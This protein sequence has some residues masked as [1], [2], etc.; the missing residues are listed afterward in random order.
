M[1]SSQALSERLSARE[2]P[3]P[4][5]GDESGQFTAAALRREVGRCADLLTEAGASAGDIIAVQLQ[6]CATLM[7]LLLAIWRLDARAMLLDHRLTSAETARLTQLCPPGF[8]VRSPSPAAHFTSA[9]ALAIQPAAAEP[10]SAEPPPGRFCLVQFTSGST[11]QSKVVA[12][13]AASLDE[14]LDRYAAIENMPGAEDRLLLLSSPVHTWGLVGGIL[15]GL[16]AGM[17]VLFASAP[18]GGAAARAAQRLSATAIFGVPSHFEMLGSMARPPPL[19]LLR[20]ATSAGAMT[21]EKVAGRFRQAFGCPLGQVYG[22]T[23]AGVVASDIAG[24]HDP[25][26]VGRPAPGMTVRVSGG[27]LYIRL[28]SSPYLRSDGVSRFDAG[29]LRTF[30]RAESRAADGVLSILGRADSVVSIGGNKID[31]MEIEQVLH[32]HPKVT[33]AVVTFGE[34]I[35][36]HIAAR[37]GLTDADLAGWCRRRLSP[38]KIPKRFLLRERLSETPTGKVIR[39]REQLLAEHRRQY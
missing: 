36:A 24:Q 22:L 30:D 32:E 31:L 7:A 35:E 18:H 1:T 8:V 19:P 2:P 27:E 23:E 9:C 39:D 13:S 20:S 4:V 37:D 17:P 38:L 33:G 10:L 11:G 25:P 3:G 29:W 28:E 6:P 15:Y 34:V 5:W 16:A 12:R 26:A 14:E 21:S